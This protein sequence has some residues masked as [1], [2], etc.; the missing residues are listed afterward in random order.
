MKQRKKDLGYLILTALREENG[1]VSGEDLARRLNITRQGLWRHIGKLESS[2][3][4]IAAVPHLGYQLLSSPDKL[5]PY[6]IQYK[7]NTKFI[8]G[9][10]H[11]YED[12][13]STQD[14]AWQLGLADCAQGT[15]VV[16]EQQRKGR[17]RLKRKW[18]APA[19]GIYFSLILRPKFILLDEVAPITLLAALAC[20]Y[21]LKKTVDLNY[22]LKWPND[23]LLGGKKIG[24][25]L[26]E[27]DAE[28][29]KIN[30][31]VLG[32]GINVNSRS[33]P[34]PATSLFLAAKKTICRAE[35]IKRILEEI[36]I[37]YRRAEQEKFSFVLRQWQKFCPLWG[38]R[39]KVKIL[40]HEIEGQALGIDEKGHL[41]LR[42]EGGIVERVS[43]G[44]VTPLP[45]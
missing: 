8:G 11:Y 32:V 1:Y 39:V 33:L 18:F 9:D 2:G 7:L 43:A 3:Y 10:I 17:G 44:D 6:E 34:P 22:S 37:L 25:I 40:D 29:D 19:G 36:E 14:A 12:I 20:I 35:L 5:L 4:Q 28:Q 45:S 16:S 24:G 42:K 27:I 38:R 23:I 30:F 41:L 21:A 26:C 15:L 31:I 13:G